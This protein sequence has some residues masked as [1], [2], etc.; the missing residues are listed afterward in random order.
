MKKTITHIVDDASWGG[1]NRLLQCLENAPFGLVHDEHKILRTERGQ[2]VVPVLKSDVVVSHMSACWKNV[3]FFSALRSAYPETPL[4]HVEHSYSER[5]V[6]LNVTRRDR[7]SDLLNITYALFDRV[8]AVSTPQAEWLA[9]R[10]YCQVDQLVTIPSCVSLSPFQRIANQTPIGPVTVGAIGRFH[11]QKG[12]DILVEAFANHLPDEIQLHL[13]GDGPDRDILKAKSRGRDNIKFI[14]KTSSPEMAMA[15]CDIIAMPSRWE[16][17]GLV[18]IEAMTSL[19]PLLC[20]SVDGLK[21]H[22]ENGAI[23]VEE[24]T[25]S[26]WTAA[27]GGLTDRAAVN[28]LPRGLGTANAEWKFIHSW[29]SIIQQL[30]AEELKFQKA[31]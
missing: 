12:F 31:A 27:L 9:R 18:A 14:E 16:P 21:Q 15:Q 1:V 28:N 17:Y 8:V 5:Y 24:N 20:A 29:N 2:S 10:N 23:A 22:I 25:V 6:A 3:P 11:E 13:V 19:R 7:F 26:G 30:T 4:I